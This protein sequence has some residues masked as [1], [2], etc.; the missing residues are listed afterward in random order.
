MTLPLPQRTLQSFL[1]KHKISPS[2][3]R[4]RPKDPTP[5]VV[6]RAPAPAH[7][8]S[9]EE[10]A[11]KRRGEETNRL[12]T[13]FSKRTKTEPSRKIAE[14]PKLWVHRFSPSCTAHLAPCQGALS[15]EVSNFC[16]ARRDNPLL[17]YQAMAIVGPPGTGK[18]CVVVA[19]LLAAGYEPVVLAEPT[20]LANLYAMCVNFEQPLLGKAPG[21]R[22]PRAFVLR[23]PHLW[24]ASPADQGDDGQGPADFLGQLSQLLVLHDEAVV[25]K[26]KQYVGHQ[27]KRKFEAKQSG[28]SK[29]Q[30]KKAVPK[31]WLDSDGQ[32]AKMPSW[33]ANQ[34][35]GGG[36]KVDPDA[37]LESL[38]PLPRAYPLPITCPLF[39]V[40][41]VEKHSKP[42]VA[43]FF[44]ARNC[45]VAQLK[46]CDAAMLASIAHQVLVRA[47]AQGLVS[48][49]HIAGEGRG[50][51]S[52]QLAAAVDGCIRGA[53]GDARQLVTWLQNEC[54]GF[55][56][57][58]RPVDRA[59]PAD[60]CRDTDEAGVF[61]LVKSMLCRCPPMHR[62]LGWCESEPNAARWLHANFS[63]LLVASTPRAGSRLSSAETE[64]RL[65]THAA[66][67]A[68][69]LSVADAH[70]RGIYG[71]ANLR[72]VT[73]LA[74]WCLLQTTM[75]GS[76]GGWRSL[77]SDFA[78][79]KPEIFRFRDDRHFA[80]RRAQEC[81]QTVPDALLVRCQRDL[82]TVVA[83]VHSLLGL[84]DVAE[85]LRANKDT[86]NV[87]APVPAVLLKFGI[88]SAA[89][90]VH[91]RSQLQW[92]TDAVP[93]SS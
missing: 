93:P 65:A 31:Q 16:T 54:E 41:N 70:G 21:D 45:K 12:L 88:A 58:A 53:Q 82:Q 91:L 32:G 11:R 2:S 68:G 81:L 89:E 67:A 42:S 14:L 71:D 79:A 17:G 84:P 83:A 40:F 59:D 51:F 3:V 64:R 74:T 10:K 61:G 25:A 50:A 37:T 66:R 62:V 43:K 15:L 39:V 78:V 8:P 5:L 26:M 19:T 13:H 27:R 76:S 28:A 6:A 47:V 23:N 69:L 24:T 90:L 60:R 72:E 33:A 92:R 57:D 29:K 86:D 38:L 46:P 20:S 56:L 34:R 22:R 77:P 55:G 18:Q 35:R 87:R 4:S 80:T 36:A 63:R 30:K 52:R 48:G 7:V 49:Q 9:P 75:P 85:W 1:D 44:K 73:L